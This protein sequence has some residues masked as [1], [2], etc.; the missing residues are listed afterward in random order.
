MLIAVT[1]KET[2]DVDILPSSLTLHITHG[3]NM[4]QCGEMH[5]GQTNKYF[6]RCSWIDKHLLTQIKLARQYIGVMVYRCSRFLQLSVARHSG[7]SHR[8]TADTMMTSSCACTDVV[9]TAS[10][11]CDKMSRVVALSA[12]ISD[13]CREPPLFGHLAVH[14]TS[15]GQKSFLKVFAINIKINKTELKSESVLRAFKN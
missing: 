1:A 4:N 5:C 8:N 13:A 2:T 3:T 10:A 6:G 9:W 12:D 15:D 11:D 14:D 7:S